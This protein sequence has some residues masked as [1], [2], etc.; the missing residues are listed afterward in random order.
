MTVAYPFTGPFVPM[1][2]DWGM[3]ANNVVTMSSLSGSVQTS[4]VPGKRWMVGMVLPIVT[5]FRQRAQVEGFF[6]SLNG[7]AVRVAIFHR[8][9]IGLGGKG[10]P[11]GT[12]NTTGVQVK[13]SASQFAPSM[14]W[15]GCGNTKTLL[16]GDMFKV[17][18]QLCMAAADSTSD[19]SGDMTVA[20][21]GGLRAVAA[22]NAAIT[23]LQPTAEFVLSNPEWRSSYRPGQAEAFGIDFVEVFS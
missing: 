23:L 12:I 6:D 5:D 11:M 1:Q 21:T 14:V 9:R 16:A 20:V 18:S 3:R 2:M 8:E 4:A 13:T 15:K 17:G 22:A 7:Q 19:S 10:T